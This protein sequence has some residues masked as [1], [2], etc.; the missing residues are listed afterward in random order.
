[1]DGR[2]PWR[3]GFAEFGL[4]SA[5]IRLSAASIWLTAKRAARGRLLLAATA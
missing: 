3:P 5:H 4:K 1:L 2:V